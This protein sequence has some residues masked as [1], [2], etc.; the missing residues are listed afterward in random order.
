MGTHSAKANAMVRTLLEARL[1]PGLPPYSRVQAEVRYGADGK[2][3][4]DFVL[5]PG[6]PDTSG[7]GGSSRGSETAGSGLAEGAGSD[8]PAK[9]PAKR[10]RSRAAAASSE[11]AEPAAL[12]PAAAPLDALAE[13]AAAGLLPGGRVGGCFLEV[14]SVTLAED[15]EQASG[16]IVSRFV[17]AAH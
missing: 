16:L 15:L 2:S 6:G 1:L 10:R 13:Q 4:V 3:R 7:G 17:L 14:K 8:G 11:A 12:T 9:R 5:L